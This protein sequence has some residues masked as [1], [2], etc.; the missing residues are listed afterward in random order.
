[1]GRRLVVLIVVA[2]FGSSV[3]PSAAAPEMPNRP[4][5]PLAGSAVS[6]S[7]QGEKKAESERALQWLERKFGLKLGVPLVVVLNE[8]LPEDGRA[9]PVRRDSHGY[10]LESWEDPMGGCRVE[11]KRKFGLTTTPPKLRKYRGLLAHEITHCLQFRAIGSRSARRMN[12]GEQ[13][14][15][16]GSADWAANEYV[17]T[18][19]NPDGDYW[20]QYITL[21]EASL[22]MRAYDAQWVLRPHRAASE[23]NGK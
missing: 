8:G 3:V 11:I 5:P 19:Y 15:S 21:P 23:R 1:M 2:G 9:R 13:W 6:Q 16:D 4:T 17:G 7:V 12:I 20:W 14:L 10:W 18:V 22:S